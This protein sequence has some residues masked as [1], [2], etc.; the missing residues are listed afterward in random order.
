MFRYKNRGHLLT[1]GEYGSILNTEELAS[2]WHFPILT[3]KAPLVKKTEAKKAEPP[4]SLPIGEETKIKPLNN[5]AQK[6][7]PPQDLPTS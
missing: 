7:S 6:A 2:L 5:K 4:M 1:L 3:V